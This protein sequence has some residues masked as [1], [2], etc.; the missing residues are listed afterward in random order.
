M[1]EEEKYR[2][3]RHQML[4]RRRNARKII[5]HTDV[6]YR[7]KITSPW[8]RSK[9]FTFEDRKSFIYACALICTLS[10]L[11]DFDA[12]FIA[13]KLIFSSTFLAYRQSRI[14][15]SVQIRKSPVPARA[16][17]APCSLRRLMSTPVLW[18]P[19]LLN[20]IQLSLRWKKPSH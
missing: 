13:W 3:I 15:I 1:E 12:I 14:R 2:I 19:P 7:V 16:T 5:R 8:F 11:S 10:L 6:Y 9:S 20:A 17:W 18:E 4:K